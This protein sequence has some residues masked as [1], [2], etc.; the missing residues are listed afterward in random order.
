MRVI[1]MIFLSMVGLTMTGCALSDL[2]EGTD[3]PTGT[4]IDPRDISTYEGAVGVYRG[5]RFSME[6]AINETSYDVSL[7]TDELS[8]TGSGY[9][10]D[11]RF[12]HRTSLEG[13]VSP[14][15][16]GLWQET[17][18]RAAQ[19]RTLLLRYGLPSA[20]PLIGHAYAMEAHAIMLMAETLCS[21]IPLT[22]VPFEGGM[23]L[24]P[25]L[26]TAELLKR[27]VALFDTA[28][29]YGRDSLPVATLARVGKGR[30]LLSLGQYTD[31]AAAVSDVTMDAAFRVQFAGTPNVNTL[32]VPFWADTTVR[33][34]DL[35]DRFVLNREGA[36]GPEWVADSVHQQDP[37]LPMKTVN[38]TFA[39]PFRQVKYVSRISSMAVADGIQA[40]LIEAESQLQPA[41]APNGPWLATLNAARATV[42]LG[43][44]QDPGNATARID[45][46]FRERAF[47]FYLTGQRL[48]DLRRL[49]RQYGR[50]PIQVYA[51][52]VY[53][54]GNASV[55]VYGDEY[56]FVPPHTEQ[57][58]NPLYKGCIDRRP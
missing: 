29:Q 27:A 16:Y 1:R 32:D 11:S 17:R 15:A 53:P 49:V 22:T 50:I 55:T 12:V 54:Y 19:A 8:T 28:L 47:W 44:L 36:N 35:Q 31:A 46:L 6:T 24:S 14:K 40:R 33:R 30:A 21:G 10:M 18:V 13:F 2:L 25:G 23:Q 57:V 48:G 58:H 7:F 41:T 38:D 9:S 5:A 39:K 42:G 26:S 34:A 3:P 4:T 20:R 51:V 56:V 52:G 37:R 43:P 45:L